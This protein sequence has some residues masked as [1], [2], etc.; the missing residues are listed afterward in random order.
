MHGP[1]HLVNEKSAV[2]CA[3]MA[4]P[5]PYHHGDLRRALLAAAIEVVGEVGPSGLRL[6]EVARRAGVSHAAP[7]HHFGDKSGLLTALAAEGW[8]L[9]A[10][11]LDDAMARTGSFLEVGVAY[12]GF[13]TTHRP[14]FE[15]MFRNELLRDDDPDLVA[16]QAAAAAVLYDPA[17]VAAGADADH[18]VVAGVAAWSLVHGLATLWLHGSLPDAVGDDPE[19]LAR[20]AASHLFGGGRASSG[21]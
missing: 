13:A 7:A 11:A 9:L 16:A 10:A 15:L 17:A 6:R 20:V 8:A 18:A 12:V 4:D 2:V 3:G 19:V 5:R 1:A 14:H 21:A